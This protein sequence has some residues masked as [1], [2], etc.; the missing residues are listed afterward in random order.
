MLKVFLVEDE[1]VI[2]EGLKANIPWEQYGY[3]FVGEASDGE[4]ALPLIRAAK[5]DVLITDIKMPFMDGLSLSKIVSSEFPKIKIVIISGYDDFEYARQAIEVGAIQYLLKPITKMTLRKTMLEMKEKIEQESEQRDWQQQFGNEMH[6]YEQFARRRFFEKLLQAEMA[7]KDIYE[8]AARLSLEISA[9]SYNLIFFSIRPKNMEGMPGETDWFMA[10]QDKILYFILRHPQYILFSWNVNFWGVLVKS[11]SVHV[12]ELTD[13]CLNH[14]RQICSPQ[15]ARLEWYVAVSRPIERLSMLHECYQKVSHYIA[16]RFIVPGMHILTES[17]LA[18]YLSV[19]EEKKI[20]H[21]NPSSVDPEIIKD[22]LRKGSFMEIHDFADSY[23]QSFQDALRS[24]MFLDYMIL[25]IR[26]TITAYLDA[27]GIAQDSYNDRIDEYLS[28]LSL[29]SETIGEY[30]VFL[31]GIAVELRDQKSDVQSGR[32]L[33]KAQEYIDV[34]FSNESLSLNE[35]AKEVGVSANYLSAIFSQNMQKT[36]IEYVT[37]KRM[38][39]ARYLLNTTDRSS[40]DIA[41]EVGYKD[42]HYFSF[43]FKK[44]VGC[45]PRE[46]RNGK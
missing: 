8:E 28:G 1:F 23:L 41:A 32:I 44:T 21:V 15:D 13:R 4:M 34:N 37:G 5:P 3:E 33:R 19:T 18:D 38:D 10:E 46:Y 2:R 31:L 39:R 35:V 16:Y 26:Y 12:E 17:T 24:R 22:F 40:G 6:E 14:I 30:F 9:E 42:P 27:L 7:V 25:S 45:T 36:F 11:E 20:G 29:N 43:V